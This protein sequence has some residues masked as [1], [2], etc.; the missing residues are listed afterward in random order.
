MQTLSDSKFQYT[1]NH[2]EFDTCFVPLVFILIKC[3]DTVKV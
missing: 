1:T 2:N 3:N